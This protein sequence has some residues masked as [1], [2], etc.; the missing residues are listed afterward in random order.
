MDEQNGRPQRGISRSFIFSIILVA[1]II[2]LL[3]W[4]F[5]S[6]AGQKQE[7]QA[8]QFVQKLYSGEVTELTVTN[9]ETVY[10]V[11][12]KSKIVKSVNEDGTV[13]YKKNSRDVYITEGFSLKVETLLT[14]S[15]FCGII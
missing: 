9:A 15:L 4:Y 8:A 11:Q 14:L 5:L 2:G 13:E 3:V 6:S 12:G 7:T 10:T 1:S